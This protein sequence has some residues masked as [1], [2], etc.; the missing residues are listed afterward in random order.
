MGNCAIIFHHFRNYHR[1][2]RFVVTT[3][4]TTYVQRRGT[5]SRFPGDFPGKVGEGPSPPTPGRKIF[6]SWRL[7][8]F[9]HAREII[10]IAGAVLTGA[11]YFRQKSFASSSPNCDLSKQ[12]SS[13]F[14]WIAID[15]LPFDKQ[16][17]VLL[18]FSAGVG[19][20]LTKVSHKARTARRALKGSN[21]RIRPPV[22]WHASWNAGTIGSRPISTL[23][24]DVELDDESFF[25]TRYDRGRDTP[26]LQIADP[27]GRTSLN[28]DSEGKT[29]EKARPELPN[30]F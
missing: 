5:E 17:F 26:A 6:F 21:E 15:I 1:Q 11:L 19:V 2:R 10:I 16:P 12:P 14:L 9:S 28:L 30:T 22:A 7:R 27:A 3:R 25:I 29:T 24:D 20:R 18:L 23:T 8:C 4:N 13:Q